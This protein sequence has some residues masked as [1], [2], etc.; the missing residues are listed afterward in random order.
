MSCSNNIWEMLFYIKKTKLLMQ[1]TVDGYKI[2]SNSQRTKITWRGN[3]ISEYAFDIFKKTVA[4]E[5]CIR[6]LEHR[7]WEGF[8]CL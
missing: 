5:I 2:L 7:L 1:K 6:S 8:S 3:L 4:D